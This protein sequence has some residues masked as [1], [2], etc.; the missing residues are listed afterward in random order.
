MLAHPATFSSYYA[1]TGVEERCL[2]DPETDH[3]GDADPGAASESSG[4]AFCGGGVEV[5]DL[6][7]DSDDADERRRARALTT[8]ERTRRFWR[9]TPLRR[10]GSAVKRGG[11][12]RRGLR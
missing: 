7:G 8:T 5:I 1:S 3:E 6:T 10:N 4:M 9:L 11:R 2:C 12:R